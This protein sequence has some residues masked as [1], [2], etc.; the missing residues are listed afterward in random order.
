MKDK[1]VVRY[2]YIKEKNGKYF[3]FKKMY[4]SLLNEQQYRKLKGK[5]AFLCKTRSNAKDKYMNLPAVI[6][7][8]SP[9]NENDLKTHTE[10]K[11]VM[12]IKLNEGQA[13]ALQDFQ[14]N[15]LHLG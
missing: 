6:A 3:I 9:A 5:T 8:I 1:Y 11:L 10:L 2:F 15:V 12:S 13:A 4:N 7:A 14:K